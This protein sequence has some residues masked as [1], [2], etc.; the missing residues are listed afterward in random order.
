MAEDWMKLYRL[1]DGRQVLVSLGEDEDDDTPQL[2]LTWRSEHCTNSVHLGFE[3]EEARDSVFESFTETQV[4]G[5]AGG[6]Q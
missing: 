6:T 2:R 4:A 5:F 3:T 1:E